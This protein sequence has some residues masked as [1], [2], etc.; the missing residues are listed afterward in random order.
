MTTP[1]S[2]N[3]TPVRVG[4]V[5]AGKYQVERVL[6]SGGMGVVIAARHVHL[7]ERFAIK[8]LL[9]EAMKKK[10]VVARF[11]RESRAA[12]Q[13]KSEHVARVFDVG[14]LDNGT[15]YMVMEFL[16]GADLSTTLKTTG[17]VP[18]PL[19]V[20][21]VLQACEAIAEAHSLRII[22]RDLK[23]ANLF[24]TKRADGSPVV[25]VIDFGISKAP[26]PEGEIEMTKTDVMMGSPAYMAP[27]QMLSARDVDE[28]ADVWSLGVILYYLVM[29]EQPYKGQTVTQ[30]YHAIMGNGPPSMCATRPDVHPA[31]DAAVAR[32]LR[33]NPRDRWA[34]VAE[35]ANAIVDHGPSHS[36]ISAERVSRTLG[37]TPVTASASMPP[38]VVL[39]PPPAMSTSMTAQ[40][41][42]VPAPVPATEA[43][44]GP[45][46]PPHNTEGSWAGTQGPV[47][48]SKS[49]VALI[50]VAATVSVAVAIGVAAL[51][52]HRGSSES[53]VGPDPTALAGSGTASNNGTTVVPAASTMA[54]VVL[55]PSTAQTTA[56]SPP[57]AL[58][59]ATPIVTAAPSVKLTGTLP[60][61][62]TPTA[63]PTVTSTHKVGD[64]F[65]D[66]H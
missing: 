39:P 38:V 42:I 28:R 64:P 24:V 34:N 12:C 13:I 50:A 31:L 7:G 1:D 46:S 11:V 32:C 51:L 54:P 60:V 20:E 61:K 2:G 36:R 43:S 48:R 19:A 22:H 18:V 56:A 55:P 52:M 10:E 47:Q 3:Y 37:F 33:A 9:P 21:Y 29:G 4:E 44:T 30:L 15:P 35:F 5:F 45:S 26:E 40:A 17:A 66:P 27:E 16:E 63:R 8:F 57:S 49:R 53:G 23:P 41:A 62:T 58:V 25:K 6:G 65:S 59:T 14:T